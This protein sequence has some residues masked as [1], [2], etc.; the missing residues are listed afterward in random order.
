MATTKKPV[1]KTAGKKTNANAKKPV[2]KLAVC[3]ESLDD[4]VAYLQDSIVEP[5]EDI[6]GMIEQTLAQLKADNVAGAQRL[7]QGTLD[8]IDA[9]LLGDEEE[10]EDCDCEDEEDED[11]E[12]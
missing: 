5:V 2:P 4:V 10:D 9:F 3:A 8:Y 7:L 11:E 12:D 6:Q 1:K